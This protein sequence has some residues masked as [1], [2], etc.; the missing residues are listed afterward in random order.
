MYA[1]RNGHT[2]TAELLLDRG[3]VVDNANT[4]GETSLMYAARDGH[5]ATAELLLERGAVIG[6]EN[7]RS[8]TA[9]VIAFQNGHAPA[10][11]MLRLC[12]NPWTLGFSGL[13]WGLPRFI[14]DR[15]LMAVLCMKYYDLPYEIINQILGI[16]RL[17]ITPHSY[18]E[19][20][21]AHRRRLR[22]YNGSALRNVL[23]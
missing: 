7:V 1:A 3:A 2:T 4:S 21:V 6:H 11:D 12:Q 17:V 19:S 8:E 14:K 15:A 5:T 18:Q 13:L 10:T 22:R 9:L 16:C 23:A 20:P